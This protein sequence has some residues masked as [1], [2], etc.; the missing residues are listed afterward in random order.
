ML[1]RAFREE[2]CGMSEKRL[3]WF[4]GREC[5]HCRK[6]TPLVD[7]FEEQSGIK[8]VRL[9]VWHNEENAKL[10]RSMEEAIAPACGGDLG[11]PAF[12]N[13]KTGKAICGRVDLEKL[14]AWAKE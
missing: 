6:L 14:M 3:I 9:E 7:Q 12:Y 8:L 1:V 2:G 5:P 13:E 10:M 4:H 11:V